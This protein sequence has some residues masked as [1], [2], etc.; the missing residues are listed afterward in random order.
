[1]DLFSEKDA[2]DLAKVK[3]VMLSKAVE[4]DAQAAVAFASLLNAETERSKSKNAMNTKTSQEPVPEQATLWT[5]K[6]ATLPPDVGINSE[7]KAYM[8]PS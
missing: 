7:G 1:M 3:E 6:V 2:A 5:D 8:I 4:G